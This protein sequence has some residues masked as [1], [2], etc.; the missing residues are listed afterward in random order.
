MEE[1]TLCRFVSYLGQ[2][3]L[4]HH[5]IKSYLSGI[6]FT[7]IQQGLD[8]P[9]STKSM[10]L[11]E[12][13]LAG[14]KH[15]QAK[16]GIPPKPRLPITPDILAHPQARWISTLGTYNGIMLWAAACT[17]RFFWLFT[18]REF[19][20]LS[21]QAYDKEV[22]LNLNDLAIDRHTNPSVIRLRIKVKQ[23]PS[24]KELTYI[25]GQQKLPSAQFRC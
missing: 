11:L 15:A 21:A 8:D 13:V 12:Y 2:Q 24:A 9:F 1:Q 25:L 19:T 20:V 17:C 7:Q 3:V 6:H 14:I 4:K 23:T 16:V 22:H 10:P 5:T 18:C